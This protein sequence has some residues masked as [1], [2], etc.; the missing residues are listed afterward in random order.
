M[1]VEKT[2]LVYRSLSTPATLPPH[3]LRSGG[4]DK[5]TQRAGRPQA[6]VLA[7]RL[8]LKR[9]WAELEVDG[10]CPSSWFAA[11]DDTAH[12]HAK[13]GKVNPEDIRVVVVIRMQRKASVQHRYWTQDSHHQLTS[14]D[15][16]LDPGAECKFSRIGQM[17]GEVVPPT[18]I[19]P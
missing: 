1:R 19:A 9:Q 13:P 7:G 5:Y 3:N 2:L 6:R 4:H 8:L 12:L 14:P 18:E 11:E 10:G 15:E 16:D 17:S